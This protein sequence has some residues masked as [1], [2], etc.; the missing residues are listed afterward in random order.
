MSM[1]GAAPVLREFRSE[2]GELLEEVG[3]PLC[4]ATK[5]TLY[6]EGRDV[7]YGKPG[8][9][10]VVRCDACSLAY[11]NPRP[12]FEAIGA[13][14]PDN[15]F[16]YL[17]PDT[18]A[19]ALQKPIA[20]VLRDGSIHRI[21]MM[22]R[23]IGRI[24]PH[25][26]IVDVGCGINDLLLNIKH[27]RG[28]VGVGVDMKDTAVRYIRETLGMPVE[29]GTF[30]EANLPANEFDLVTMIEY[31]EHDGHPLSAIA[32]ARRIL[33]KGGHLVIEIPEPSGWPAKTF[34]ARWANLDT[35]R[36]LIYFERETLRRAF[37]K[38]GIEL[39]HYHS[40]TKPFYIGISILLALGYRDVASKPLLANAL[41]IVPSL[42]FL[43]FM[44][45][46]PEFTM[47]VGRAI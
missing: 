43:P 22:E 1:V 41:S 5:S 44:K 12:T 40:F 6:L 9:Y 15:Y 10:P 17:T 37:A 30:L 39:V 36:H 2:Y 18:F 29:H 42:P 4:G 13:H 38:H 20:S 45:W 33:K 47:A 7:L 21:E 27:E 23:M 11:V 34:K 35:P 8:T 16:C 26:K 19:P 31:L 46:L 3:C 24:Q 14:Y 28:A 25:H 32:E